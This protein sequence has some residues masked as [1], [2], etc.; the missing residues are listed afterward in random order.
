M[1]CAI[2]RR[3]GAAIALTPAAALAH[4]HHRGASGLISGIAHPLAIAI[5]T[6]LP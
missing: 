2:A 1:K 3:F 4:L 5:P 6:N